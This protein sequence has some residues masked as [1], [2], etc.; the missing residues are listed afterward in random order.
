MESKKRGRPEG[1]NFEFIKSIKLNQKQLDNWDSKKIKAFL[2]GS[3]KPI[4]PNNSEVMLNYKR[5]YGIMT[6]WL[7]GKMTDAQI[8]LIPDKVLDEIDKMVEDFNLE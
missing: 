8:S 6:S 7:L 2:D 4:E 5:L 1:K 3:L